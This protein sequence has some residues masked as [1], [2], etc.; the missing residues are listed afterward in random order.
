MDKH[1]ELLVSEIVV[2]ELEATAKSEGLAITQ[3]FQNQRKEIFAHIQG[4]LVEMHTVSFQILE[5]QT[6][7]TIKKLFGLLFPVE[8]ETVIIRARIEVEVKLLKN[9]RE[10][11]K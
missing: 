6:N 4:Y 3:L 8:H 10:E 1:T 9:Q 2:M 7:R 5:Q 11:E